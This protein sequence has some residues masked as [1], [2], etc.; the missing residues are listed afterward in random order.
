MTELKKFSFLRLIAQ[1]YLGREIRS[2]VLCQYGRET[3][4]WQFMTEEMKR[5][6]IES[7]LK[8][9]IHAVTFK[10]PIQT[11][12]IVTASTT[13]DFVLADSNYEI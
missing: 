2:V 8:T 12:N 7:M 4:A 13:H 9:T 5:M 3:C 11:C 1:I 6:T 10:F